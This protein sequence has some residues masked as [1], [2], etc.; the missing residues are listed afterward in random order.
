MAYALN[1]TSG[2][3][4]LS[5]MDSWLTEARRRFQAW[6]AARRTEAELRR[7]SVEELDDLGL[8][9]LSLRDV[10]RDSAR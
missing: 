9:G 6:R 5:T 2:M 4:S 10:A 3:T 7:L 8:A 1:Q